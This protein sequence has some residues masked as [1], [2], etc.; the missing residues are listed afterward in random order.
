MRVNEGVLGKLNERPAVLTSGERYWVRDWG[1]KWEMEREDRNS[2][3]PSLA[4]V[5]R[6]ARFDLAAS[7]LV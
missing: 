5:R 2:L 4:P 6:L 7:L 3:A 1:E